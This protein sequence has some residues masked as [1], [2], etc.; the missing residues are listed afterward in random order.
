M[1]GDMDG[2]MDGHM[3]GTSHLETLLSLGLIDERIHRLAVARLRDPGT[4]DPGFA[5][6]GQMLA[7]LRDEGILEQGGDDDEYLARLDDPGNAEAVE[8]VLQ[9]FLHASRASAPDPSG[10]GYGL[11]SL[12]LGAVAVVVLGAFVWD[13]LVASRTPS[14]GDKGILSSLRSGASALARAEERKNPLAAMNDRAAG[15]GLGRQVM[16]AS[17]RQPQEIAYLQEERVRLCSV[18]VVLDDQQD[19]IGYSITPTEGGYELRGAHSEWLRA[20][21]RPVADAG[22]P[23]GTPVITEAFRVASDRLEAGTGMARKLARQGPASELDREVL[24]LGPC[25]GGD[26]GVVTCPLLFQ[27]NDRLI[28][29]L[30]G[31]GLQLVKGDF[32]FVSEGAG[33]RAADGFDDRYVEAVAKGRIDELLVQ[34]GAE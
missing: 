14:C 5:N 4:G 9:D 33:W 29:A 17:F 12:V 8:Q 2:H 26:A 19:E 28:Q 7:W 22:A 13:L 6:A 30:G 15:N 20:K 24:P 10:R 11:L 18:T 25:V 1:D 16:R 31:S 3:D 34:P 32:D 27:R 23:L 21:Y